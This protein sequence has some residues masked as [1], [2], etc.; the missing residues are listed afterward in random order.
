MTILS[1]SCRPDR[2]HRAPAPAAVGW[3]LNVCPPLRSTS[4]PRTND[5]DDSGTWPGLRGG[6]SSPAIVAGSA[7]A[8]AARISWA[9]LW[10]DEHLENH[11]HRQGHDDVGPRVEHAEAAESAVGAPPVGQEV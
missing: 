11:G 8:A 4:S 6:L 7:A 1:A 2:A 5:G 10:P 3:N 9:S